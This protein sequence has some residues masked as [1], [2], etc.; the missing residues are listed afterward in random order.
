MPAPAPR[1]HPKPPAPGGSLQLHRL[2]Q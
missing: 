2:L 1:R